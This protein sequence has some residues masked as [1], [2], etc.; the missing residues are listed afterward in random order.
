MP[1]KKNKTKIFV[2]LGQVNFCK[3][4]LTSQSPGLCLLR[5][6]PD[7]QIVERQLKLSFKKYLIWGQG[8]KN[9]SV[10]GVHGTIN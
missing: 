2:A 1:Y 9:H 7:L 8:I 4:T 6:T 5:K 10:T 3:R